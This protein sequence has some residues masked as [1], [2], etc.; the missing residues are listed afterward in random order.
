MHRVI[1]LSEMKGKV[2]AVLDELEDDGWA[3]VTVDASNN[4][5]FHHPPVRSRTM[6]DKFRERLFGKPELKL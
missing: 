6:L 4:Y 3:L 5:I 1:N 2:E